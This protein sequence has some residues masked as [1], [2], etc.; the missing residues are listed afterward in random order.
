AR[1]RAPPDSSSKASAGGG[2]ARR[3]PPRRAHRQ[4]AAGSL[5]LGRPAGAQ[6]PGRAGDD[7]PPVPDP[8]RPSR[9]HG[10]NPP[11]THPRA[12][13]RGG[14]LTL[15]SAP[16]R[17]G[18]GWWLQGLARAM[19]DAAEGHPVDFYGLPVTAMRLLWATEEGESVT[20]TARRF[21]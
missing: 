17:C 9:P 15:L 3:G 10:A 5:D 2:G 21:G 13:G 16:P 14:L 7:R 1:A 11:P 19:Q 8:D 4:D 12:V 20:A 18:K 6:S